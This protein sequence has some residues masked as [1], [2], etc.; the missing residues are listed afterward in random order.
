MDYPA[1]MMTRL[2]FAT[3]LLL[4]ASVNAQTLKIATIAP[5]GSVWMREMRAASKAVEDATEGRVQVRYYPGGVMGDDAT[6]MRKVRLGQLQ[7][8]GFSISELSTVH[9]NVMLYS[10]PFLFRE[11]AEVD[12]VRARL[13]DRLKAGIA[14]AGWQ[15][16]SISGIGFAYVMSSQPIDTR[17][18][19]QQR[20]VWVPR[21][22]EISERSFR[23]AGI[24]PIPL[25]L[26]DVFTALQTGMIDTVGNTPAGAI[27]LQ[28]H[29]RLR[30]LLD[31]PASYV[32][33]I[34]AVDTRSWNKI[35]EAD[36]A[37]LLRE[38]D[39]A[40]RRIDA[41]NLRSDAEAIQALAKLGV[42]IV[43]PSAEEFARWVEVGETVTEGLRA[44]GRIDAGMLA[45]IRT[46][47]AGLRAE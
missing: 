42:A 18:A 23:A 4:C 21:N 32:I 11:R 26:P 22:D 41:D 5:D 12:A 37:V 25:P 13:D 46:I 31:M 33:G 17:E 47:L 6:V 39:A 10:L 7:G 40:S 2:L 15:V 8:G 9:S 29:S 14:D 28:W 1:S 3:L 35:A 43:K 36:R 20:K 30:Y 16:L 24:A 34:I 38:F 45:E 19:M 44:E 27:A